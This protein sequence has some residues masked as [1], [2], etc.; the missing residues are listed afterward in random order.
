MIIPLDK[1]PQVY[2]CFDSCGTLIRKHIG[3]VLDLGNY[4]TLYMYLIIKRPLG[5]SGHKHRYIRPVCLLYLIRHK[6]RGICPLSCLFITARFWSWASNSGGYDV[7]AMVKAT[8]G[9][10]IS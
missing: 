4:C 1:K 6:H 3:K 7:E 10:V 5:Y 8:K 9:K 2:S